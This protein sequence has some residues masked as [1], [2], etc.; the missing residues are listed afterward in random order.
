MC[1]NLKSAQKGFTMKKLI[2]QAVADSTV[3]PAVKDFTSLQ[4]CLALDQKVIFILFGDICNIREIIALIHDHDKYAFVHADM[5]TGL[6][7]RDIA[8]DFLKSCC[9]DGILSTRPNVIKRAGELGLFTILRVFALDSKSLDTAK[10]TVEVLKLDMIEIMPGLM[11]MI[12]KHVVRTI[13]PKVLCGGLITEK[14]NIIDALN[15]GAT[16]V[17]ATNENLWSV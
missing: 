13:H 1:Y 2:F 10:K 11:P 6:S 16:A 14:S 5:I 3:I 17:S 7:S 9:V 4:R 15:A 12:V 8:A